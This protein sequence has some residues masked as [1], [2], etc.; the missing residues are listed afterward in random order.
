MR[1]LSL[2]CVN[3]SLLCVNG[4]LLC[5]N[6]SLLCV[7]GSLLLFEWVSFGDWMGFFCD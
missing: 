3:G 2:L 6:G 4:S 5:V 1:D 7:N